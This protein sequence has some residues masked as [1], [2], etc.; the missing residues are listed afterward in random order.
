MNRSWKY[1]ILALAAILVLGACEMGVGTEVELEDDGVVYSDWVVPS[2][3]VSSDVAGQTVF[4]VEIPAPE[5]TTEVLST[6]T[7]LVYARLEGYLTEVWP[8]GEVGMLP[9]T[10]T[11]DSNGVQIDTWSARVIEG[12]IEIQFVNSTNLYTEVVEDHAFRYVVF[13]GGGAE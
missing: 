11:Y 2:G 7:V 4:T 10:L 3:Y 13:P 12:S 1:G 9:V 6:G 8:A 5:V